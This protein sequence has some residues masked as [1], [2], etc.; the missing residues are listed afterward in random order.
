[1]KQST[2]LLSL[3]LA[4]VMAFSFVTVI[5]NAGLVEGQVS[6]DKVDDANLTPEQVATIIMDLLDGLIADAQM[7]DLNLYVKKIRMDSLDHLIGDLYSIYSNGFLWGIAKLA[8]GDLGGLNLDNLSDAKRSNGDLNFLYDVLELLS[9]NKGLLSDLAY[10]IGGDGVSLGILGNF[11]DLG[12][13]QD[14]LSD[15]PG[16][17]AEVVYDL[18]I[19]GS[20]ADDK[21]TYGESNSFF[22]VEELE[23]KGMGL[24]EGVATLDDILNRAVAGLLKYPQDYDYVGEGDAAVKDWNEYSLLMPTI[25][26]LEIDDVISIFSL[27]DDANSIFGLLDKIAP[28]AIYDLGV[29]ALNHNLKKTLLEAVEVEFNEIN[30]AVLPAHVAADFEVDAEDG[31]ETY[32]NYIAYDRI[33]QD[34]DIFYYTT[35]ETEAVL[36]KGEP[37]IDEDGNEKTRKE[38]K[39]FRANTAGANAFYDLIDFNWDFVAPK[40]R[41]DEVES[42]DF[43]LDNIAALNYDA[44]IAKYGSIT[45]SLNHLLYVVFETAVKP[46]VKDHFAEITGDYWADGPTTAQ[47]ENL[48]VEISNIMYNAERL[49]KY[50]ISE[51][52]DQIFGSDS[53]YVAWEYA[54]VENKTITELIALIGPTFFEDVM[55]QLIMPKNADGSYAFHKGTELLEFGTLVIREFITEITP[56]VNYDTY[57]FAEGTVTTAK[58]RHFKVQ[59][60]ENWYNIILNMGLDIAYTY[61]DN[62]TNFDEDIPA[63]SIEESRWQG[64]LDK[65]IMWAVNYVGT[66]TSS[67]LNGLDPTNVS[68]QTG[69][70]KKL[71]LFLN[72]LLPLGFINGCTSASWDFDVELFFTKFKSFLT[73]FDLTLLASLFGRNDGTIYGSDAK[74]ADH[75]NLLG[76]EKAV[77]AVLNLVNR[78]LKLVFGENLLPTT[79]NLNTLVTKANIKT[80]LS[81]LFG[82]FY[83]RKAEILENG[84][85]VLAKFI[86]EWGG[87]QEIGTPEMSLSHTVVLSNGAGSYSFGIKNGSTGVWRH[88]KDA[89]GKEHTDKQ[90]TYN[91]VSV[92]AYDYNGSPSD[93]VTNVVHKYPEVGE[94]E[95]TV[96]DFGATSTV[97]YDVANVPEEGAIVRFEVIY[98]VNDEDGNV[99]ANGTQFKI[100]EFAW[101]NYKGSTERTPISAE[102]KSYRSTIFSPNYI[103]LSDPFGAISEL[104]VGE[105]WREHVIGGGTEYFDIYPT[106]GTSH[107]Q[108]GI[109]IGHING[110]TVTKDDVKS[111]LFGLGAG[112]LKDATNIRTGTKFAKGQEKGAALS[113]TDYATL[114]IQ[115]FKNGD[116]T[117]KD[118]EGNNK[119]T[120]KIEGASFDEAEWAKEPK[121]SGSSTSWKMSLFTKKDTKTDQ[122]LKLI[123]FDDI[124]RNKIINL[125]NDENELQRAALG[126]YHD[127]G[128][129]YADSVLEFNDDTKTPDENEK[130]TNFEDTVWIDAEGNEVAKD[131][132]GAKEVTKINAATAYKNYLD[133]LKAAI[134]AAYQEWNDKSIFDFEKRYNDLRIAANDVEFIKMTPEEIK[135]AGGANIDSQVTELEE[136]LDTVEATYSDTKDYTD[137]KMYRMN[138]YNDARN[139]ARDIVNA[140]HA[141]LLTKDDLEKYFPY[142]SIYPSE[143]QTLVKGDK[144]EAFILALLEDYDEEQIKANEDN[145]ENA[146]NH[147]AGYN[148]LDVAQAANLLNRIPLRLLARDHGVITKYLDDEIESAKNMIGTTNNGT[149]TARS[150][151]KYDEAYKEALAVQANPT[152]MTVFD[153][154]YNLMTSRNELVLVD[155]EADYTELEALIA[156]ATQAL[157]N[158]NLYN[159]T[160]KEFGQVLAELGYNDFKNAD[161]DKVQLF[162]GS[163]LHENLEPYAEDEQYKVDRAATALKEALARLKFKNVTITGANIKTEEIAPE[164]KVNN[165]PAIT[166]SVARIA[167]ELDKDA[168]KDLFTVAGA[169]VDKDNII[170]SND[171]NYTVETE[172]EFAFAG[173]NATVTFYTVVGGVKVPVATVKVVVEADVNGDGTLDVLDGALTELVSNKNAELEGCYFIAAN[174]DTATKDISGADYSAVVNKVLA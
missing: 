139:E 106:V 156:Q 50:L 28:Y 145:L 168:I 8:L 147:Y 29:N 159:N 89:A 132:K 73:T 109:T 101:L 137:Y 4:L 74:K 11:I 124:N 20:Y 146:K 42:D 108:H 78:I 127:E 173:T 79:T 133:A 102:S 81:T 41:T 36:E 2:K 98:T 18:L 166:A 3:V 119:E 153:A 113:N 6:Y 9:V 59:S 53:P 61:L 144:Y 23:K 104:N 58:D 88:Y 47:V 151:A 87:E 154:K 66:D 72:T 44:L 129:Y 86:Q 37:V 56:N 71:S 34:G 161:G 67:I 39:Y 90:Y 94:K 68:K 160:A 136:Q 25:A 131:T 125:V 43:A 31:K 162:Y 75:Y 76:S 62:L 163:A 84:L 143:L 107:T 138:R 135:N 96:L 157:A 10:G 120:Y 46:E 26:E 12:D 103:P 174:L 65:V 27:T 32:V 63:Q 134:P 121:T 60:A 51:F 118:S 111:G 13:I 40:P 14:I 170:V 126:Y 52:A 115:L 33:Y 7:K 45:E 77:T 21:A 100:S 123:Y 91:I 114:G 54:D 141:T 15:L 5:G 49:L 117:F 165:I 171:V 1:M 69:P 17:A 22:S 122:E 142:T 80:L 97:T 140:Y 149:Y 57:I 24:P 70:F 152:Q 19:H 148:A 169:S 110:G 164:D 82:A 35:L 116:F 99:M 150:W 112:P 55:P 30:K 128:Y 38:R 130:V 155:K 105:I 167:P 48:D 85:P 92:N 95:A 172:K 83:T 16:F 158:S 64:M 93:Y